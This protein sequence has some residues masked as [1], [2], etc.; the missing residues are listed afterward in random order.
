MLDGG[1]QS[2]RQACNALL[3][4]Q[5][6]IVLSGLRASS[7]A[8]AKELKVDSKESEAKEILT[9]YFAAAQFLKEVAV[10][11][12]EDEKGISE[13]ILQDWYRNYFGQ[14][15]CYVGDPKRGDFDTKQ[16]LL[17]DAWNLFIKEKLYLK[18]QP[19][20]SYK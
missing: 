3:L 7:K 19:L 2:F 18:I 1:A 15:K 17:D 12:S 6:I 14:G 5:K 9:P 8:F 16:Q 10:L 20:V 11:V 13:T 4:N